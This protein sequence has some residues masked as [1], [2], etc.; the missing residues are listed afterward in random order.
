[1]IYFVQTKR[2][3]TEPHSTRVVR[4][5]YTSTVGQD[6]LRQKVVHAQYLNNLSNCT[7]VKVFG[8]GNFKKVGKF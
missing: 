2:K 5:N 6:K 4:R 3:N 7:E 1:M 8:E